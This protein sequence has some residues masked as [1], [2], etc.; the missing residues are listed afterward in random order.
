MLSASFA[1][2]A[3][4]FMD[5]K[6]QS[7]FQHLYTIASTGKMFEFRDQ[8]KSFIDMSDVELTEAFPEFG[9][10]V[11]SGKMREIFSK[12]ISRSEEVEKNYNKLNDKYINPFDRR[13]YTSGTREYNTEAIKESAFNHAKFMMMF[14]KNTFVRAVE[15]TN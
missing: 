12:M 10:D 2:D 13:K 8:I 5:A 1:S 3:L 4:A 9:M 11:K 7:I 14:T 6:D 15:R